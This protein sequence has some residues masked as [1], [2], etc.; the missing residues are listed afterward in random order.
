[1]ARVACLLDQRVLTAA[2]VC[3][4]HVGRWARDEA[5]RHLAPLLGAAVSGPAQCRGPQ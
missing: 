4:L 2:N 5:W 1:M 3:G